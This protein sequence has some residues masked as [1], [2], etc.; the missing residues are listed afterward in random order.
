MMP[1]VRY[2]ISRFHIELLNICMIYQFIFIMRHDIITINLC[3]VKIEHAQFS[4]NS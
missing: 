2:K 1:P 3:I 4:V